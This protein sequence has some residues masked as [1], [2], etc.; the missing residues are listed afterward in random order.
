MQNI[1]GKTDVCPP[2]PD[3]ISA[4]K[5]QSADK[6]LYGMGLYDYLDK[7]GTPH[8]IGSYKMDM[9]AWNDLDIDIE[10]HAMSAEK[11]YEL[12]AF[13]LHT[14]HPLWYEAKEEI[15]DENKT[16]WFHGFHTI[17]DG[18]LWNLDLW[19][20]DKE[21]IYKAEHY[22]DKIV[23]KVRQKPESREYIIKIKQDLL[24]QDL[25]NFYQYSSMDVYRAVLEQGITSTDELLERYVK[26]ENR[27]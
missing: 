11:L 23:N 10:N 2:L 22:C 19:F 9:M 16:V 17:V 5:K 13:I 27:L 3:A 14:F 20:F 8:I 7:I 12:T 24:E 26:V 15:N 25:Y 4:R 18:E 21:T 1:I 6:I